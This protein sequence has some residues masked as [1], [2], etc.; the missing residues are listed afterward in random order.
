MHFARRPLSHQSAQNSHTSERN[1]S[2]TNCHVLMLFITSAVTGKHSSSV[3]PDKMQKVKSY[4]FCLLSNTQVASRFMSKTG[5][6]TTETNLMHSFFPFFFIYAWWPSFCQ[7]S[8]KYNYYLPFLVHEKSH[9]ANYYSDFS[10]AGHFFNLSTV[11]GRSRRY[12]LRFPAGIPKHNLVWT[13]YIKLVMFLN[14]THYQV[15]QKLLFIW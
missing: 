5:T 1:K 12:D 7:Y 14:S 6:S 9:E 15:S 10:P 13:K 11:M 4:N 3:S 2:D 8:N